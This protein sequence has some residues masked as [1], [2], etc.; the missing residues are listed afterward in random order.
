MIIFLLLNL[1]VILFAMIIAHLYFNYLNTAD[2]ILCIALFYFSFIVATEQFLGLLN[3]ITVQNLLL[4][5]LLVL[6][7][8]FLLIRI[9]NKRWDL[10]HDFRNGIRSFPYNR[11][12][13]FFISIILG[14][15]LVKL[16][17]NLINPPFGWDSLN[18]HFTFA[19]EWFKHKN[20]DTPLVIS[21]NPCPSYYPL[22]AS[23]I[24][25]WLIFPFKNVF[26]ADL[27][28]APFFVLVFL[29]VYNICR[30]LSVS[31]EYSLFAAVLM[32]ITPNYFKQLSI[33][34]VD[35]MLC[36]WFLLSL[37]FLL[38]LSRNFDFKNVTLFSF[39]LGMLIGTKT[40]ALPYSLILIIFFIYFLFKKKFNLISFYLFMAFLVFVAVVGSFSYI[41]NFIQTGN[42]LYP[43]TFKIFSKVIFPGVMDKTNFTAFSKLEDYGLAKVLFHEGMGAGTILFIIPGI[44]LFIFTLFKK[45]KISINDIILISTFFFLYLAYRY[46]F[47]LPNVRYLY[48]MIGIGY[49]ISFYALSNIN[50]PSKIL[51]WAVL[52]SLLAAMPEMARRLELVISLSL[53]FLLFI[54]L[55]IGYKYLQKNLLKIGIIVISILIFGLEIVNTSYNKYEFQ[56]YIETTKYSGFWPDATRAWDWLNRNTQGNNI[57]YIGR[58]VPFP[59]YGSNFKNNVYYVSVNKT[60]PAKIHYFPK[61]HYYWGYDF[62]TLHR[63]L[64]EKGNYRGDANYS[65]WLNNLIKRNTDYLFVYSLH[66]TKEIEFPLE[67][68]WAK[69]NPGKFSPVFTNGT[70]H[71]YKIVGSR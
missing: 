38:Y 33:A 4:I 32:T 46:I 12:V 9:K 61:S 54:I 56:R 26:L 3:I 1:P 70:I 64:E 6:L 24:Y 60:E 23:L 68:A 43:L 51:R 59:L 58:P 36:A 39:S 67:D 14:F 29:A 25:L 40:I 50:F 65:V 45:K 13:I 69:A 49:V 34:Y 17:Y 30:K 7:A 28:Q 19:V 27:G 55:L 18:Y 22:N 63:N 44:V 42:P 48:P 11:L 37:N 8:S 21:D 52:V 41:R 31:K 66:Q 15:S 16:F 71:I 2:V 62:R 20:L 47:S 5:N 57:A 53:S 10:T 35:V